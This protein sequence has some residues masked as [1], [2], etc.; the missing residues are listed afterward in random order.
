MD[1]SAPHTLNDCQVIELRHYTLHANARDTLVELFER[2]LIEPQEAAG[3]CIAGLFSDRDDPNRFVWLR[4]FRDHT[5]RI[6]ALSTFYGGRV[7]AA[8]R[9]AANATMVDSDNVLLLRA[10][11]PPRPLPRQVSRPRGTRRSSAGAL[12]AVDP[13]VPEPQSVQ[14]H[15]A[16][17]GAIAP[18]CKVPGSS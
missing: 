15:S 14:P 12:R 1:A 13:V 8:H 3:M 16:A 18:L 7:W 2:E 11:T 6:E 5:S 17:G 9:D 10:T 4:G